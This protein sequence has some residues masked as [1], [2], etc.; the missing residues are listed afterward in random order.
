[1]RHRYPLLVLA[2]ILLAGVPEGMLAQGNAAKSGKSDSITGK[3]QRA[4]LVFGDRHALTLRAPDGWMLDTRSG[5]AQGLQ[6][7]FYPHGERWAASPSVMYCQV[8]ARGKDIADRNAMI[9]YDQNRFRSSGPTAVIASGDSIVSGNGTR[10][11]TSR[12][13]GGARGTIEAVAYIEERSVVVL[14]VLSCRSPEIFERSLPAFRQLVGSYK[15]LAD[16]QENIMRA[17]EAA[18]EF[19]FGE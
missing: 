3:Q 14:V 6:A 16:D 4:A 19:G 5:R 11:P 15:F 13:S 2:A 9:Q 7:V 17:I 1:M 12:F 8:V 10:I 18:E